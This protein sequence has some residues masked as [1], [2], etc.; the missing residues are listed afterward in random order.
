MVYTARGRPLG[1]WL[2]TAVIF[3]EGLGLVLA[4]L[5]L[6]VSSPEDWLAVVTSAA[7]GCLLVFK[8]YRLWGFHRRAWLVI[9]VASAIGAC[10][11]TLELARGHREPSTW[12]A[13]I[14]A[15]ATLLYLSHPK[16][17]ALF[18]QTNRVSSASSA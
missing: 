16:V 10:T 17:R 6:V 15:A 14:W 9:L 5:Q 3:A 18:V 11:H 8:A 2:L 1:L 4:A 13:A 7:L 12:L